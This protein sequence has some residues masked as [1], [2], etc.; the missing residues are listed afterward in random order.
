MENKCWQ[1]N[2]HRLFS[3]QLSIRVEGIRKAFFLSNFVW[4]KANFCFQYRAYN[5]YTIQFSSAIKTTL[6]WSGWWSYQQ[7]FTHSCWLFS[8]ISTSMFSYTLYQPFLPVV[9]SF[10]IIEYC[11]MSRFHCDGYVDT[12]FPYPSIDFTVDYNSLSAGDR[13]LRTMF[14]AGYINYLWYYLDI[15]TPFLYVFV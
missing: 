4:F 13:S 8:V 6:C 10:T 5:L 11:N 15:T 2:I 7:I 14:M 12:R 1:Y 3:W 9:F